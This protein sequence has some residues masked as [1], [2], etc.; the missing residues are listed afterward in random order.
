MS[1][2][3]E[4]SVDGT[5]VQLVQSTDTDLL[6]QVDVSGDRSSSLVEPEFRFLGRQF[7]TGRGLDEVNVTGH[8]ELTL[9]LQEQSVSVDEVLSRNVSNLLVV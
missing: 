9:S 1:V 2:G 7:V 5:T 8:F 3:S 6:S 4:T